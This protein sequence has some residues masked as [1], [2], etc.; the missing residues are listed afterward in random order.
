[1]YLEVTE[2]QY[3]KFY[4]NSVW[5]LH[6]LVLYLYLSVKSSFC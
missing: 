4:F 5:R 2:R 6:A 3:K 1:M